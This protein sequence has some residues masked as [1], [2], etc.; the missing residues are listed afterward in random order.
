MMP[1][2][3]VQ[4]STLSRPKS[5]VS[6]IK[7]DGINNIASEAALLKRED[8][9]SMQGKG[10]EEGRSQSPDISDGKPSVFNFQD[11]RKAGTSHQFDQRDDKKVKFNETEFMTSYNFNATHQILAKSHIS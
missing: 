1:D 7:L 5:S 2:S 4:S 6:K 3:R 9:L 10:Q 8:V 11:R